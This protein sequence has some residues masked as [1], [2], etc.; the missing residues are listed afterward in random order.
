MQSLHKKLLKKNVAFILSALL[1][2]MSVFAVTSPVSA[3]PGPGPGVPALT[4]ATAAA[5]SDGMT[6]TVT[7]SVYMAAAGSDDDLKAAITIVR[8]GETSFSRLGDG[9]A[10]TLVGAGMGAELV[11]T[12]SD[13]LKGQLNGIGIAVGAL[14]NSSGSAYAAA[15]VGPIAGLDVAPMFIG[16]KT[17]ND[18]SV[19]LNFDESITVNNGSQDKGEFLLGKISLATDGVR[20]NPLQEVFIEQPSGNAIHLRTNWD[21]KVVLGTNARLKIA[22]G[23]FQDATGH[24]NDDMI[25][26]VASPVIQSAVVSSDYRTVTVTFNKE[27]F[28]HTEFNDLASSIAVRRDGANPNSRWVYLGSGDE[29]AIESGKLVV[30]LVKPLVGMTNYIRIDGDALFD[31]S[32]NFSDDEQYTPPIAGDP[33]GDA[34]PPEY[35]GAYVSPGNQEV[36]IIFDEEVR[37]HGDMAAL[38][39]KI[40]YYSNSDHVSRLLPPDADVTLTGNKL[41]VRFPGV[42]FNSS[43][44]TQMR[45]G[46]EAIEDL[47]GNVYKN[48]IYADALYDFYPSEIYLDEGQFSHGGRWM[49]MEFLMSG[50][51]GSTSGI[52]LQDATI[53]GGISHLHS[54]ISVSTDRGGNYRPLSEQDVIRMNDNMMTVFF[55][56]PIR[57]GVVYVKIEAGALSNELGNVKLLAIDSPVAYNTPDVVGYF[58]SDAPSEFRFTDEAWGSVIREIHVYDSQNNATWT[59]DG[60]DY[61]ISDNKLTI[62]PGVFQNGI[63]YSLVIHAEG[64]SAHF[65]EGFTY[66]SGEIFYMT[67][68]KVTK[69]SGITATIDVLNLDT[70]FVMMSQMYGY[71]TPKQSVV[72][73]LMNGTTPVSIVAGTFSVQTGTYSANFQ[74]AD[75]AANPNYRVKA[76]VVSEWNADAA[77]VGVNLA[78]EV[79]QQEFD[80]RKF[81]WEV[82]KS[83][84]YD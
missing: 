39:S 77:S 83:D 35:L 64:Y 25:L 84:F 12:L 52:Q 51:Y 72:F 34:T 67:A 81:E 46:V 49:T 78:T 4:G 57:A 23:A 65:V 47:Y 14:M 58:L 17:S 9:D 48:S 24:A 45:I 36:T 6:V 38:K 70:Y 15:W 13:A 50:K 73:E 60:D 79:T 30:R 66:S 55:H 1:A 61:T 42:V 16:A 26:E 27:V 3:D 76:F 20:F 56:E 22:A 59:L 33:A 80:R 5:S 11:I 2:V 53:D 69:T 54:K 62:L 19:V 63:P 43:Y 31:S 7:S 82:G 68:P 44:Y 71:P 41:T 29:A 18:G 28:A 8:T 74:V 75:A 21:M 32:G 40:E 37:S 10:V